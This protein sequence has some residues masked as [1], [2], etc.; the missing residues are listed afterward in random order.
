[1]IAKLCVC[2]EGRGGVVAPSFRDAL[3]KLCTCAHTSVYINIGTNTKFYQ[4]EG[5]S[6]TM[7]YE[8]LLQLNHTGRVQNHIIFVGFAF[9]AYS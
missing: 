6:K 4:G 7:S 3:R 9:N 8:T 1:M 2:F 5:K